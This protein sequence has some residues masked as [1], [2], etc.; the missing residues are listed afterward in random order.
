MQ[1]LLLCYPSVRLSE[2][3]KGGG[4]ALRTVRYYADLKLIKPARRSSSGERLFDESG[5]RQLRFVR[6]MRHLG[7]PLKEVARLLRATEQLSCRPSSEVIVA[8]LRR[9]GAAVE[10]R[11]RELESVRHALT[12]LLAANGDGCTDD[13]CLCTT[14]SVPSRSPAPIRRTAVE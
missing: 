8:Q 3:A 4:V 2:L 9:H 5:L 6:R 13:L 10:A 12:T 11:L 7:L 14:S 1:C